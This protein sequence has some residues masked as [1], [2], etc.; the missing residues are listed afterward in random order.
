MRGFIRLGLGAFV[1]SLLVAGSARAAEATLRISHPMPPAHHI[2]KLIEAFA[3]D[4]K[5]RSNGRIDVQ[6]F[7]AE[8]AY[9][10]A[11]NI[12]AVARGQIE[13]AVSV[14]F[15]WGDTI[16]EMNVTTLPYLLSDLD[17]IQRF[18]GSPAAKL[19]EEKLTQKGVRNLAW[20]YTTR[21]IVFTSQKRPLIDPADFKGVKI[22]GLNKLVDGGL[23]ALGAAPSAM[24]AS[25]VYQAL[26][27]G[28]LD[29]GVTDLAAVYSRKYYEVQKYGTIGPLFTVFYH[30][31][32][33]PAWFAKLP[34]DL[35]Q[36]VIEAAHKAELDAIPA[37]E[38]AAE[39]AITELGAKGMILHR[40]S[41]E[42]I[43]IFTQAM[44]PPVLKAFIAASPDGQK[45]LD[46]LGGL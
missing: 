29:A 14:N 42:E 40:Q 36:I 39:D 4:I 30:L 16:P 10:A 9:K 17:K 37:T 22:R 6:V 24:P 33:N 2:A 11:Q 41:P 12:P 7:A 1:A 20:L 44:Q 19:L 28:V 15:Q 46:L 35:R 13:A 38:A 8:Q 23:V 32:V 45:M 26:Q 31:Y 25:E 18:P 43:R 21:Q 3:A 34:V 27:S 5:A